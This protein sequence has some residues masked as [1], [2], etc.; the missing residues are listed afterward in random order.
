V[1]EGSFDH[2]DWPAAQAAHEAAIAAGGDGEAYQGLAVALF[3]QNEVDGAI[4]AMEHAY[5]LFRREAALGRAAWAALWIAGQYSRHKGNRSV[6]SGWVARCERLLVRA[7]PSAETGRV[8]LIRALA[9]NDPAQI[10]GAAE[11]AMEIA[12]RFGDSDYEALALAYSGLAMLSLGRLNEGRARLDEAMAATT[13]GE[14]RAPEAVGQI[15][16]AMLA[17]C[18][19]TVDFQRAEQWRQVA[20]PFLDAYDQVGVTGTCRATYAGVLAATGDWPEAELEL[21]HALR[22]FDAFA[23]G[24]RA[25]AVVRMA[26]LRIRQGRLDEATRLME[27]NEGHPDAQL[28][29]AELELAR[30]R[31]KVAAA[32]LERRLHQLGVANL[33]AAP[34]LLRLVEAQITAG[35]PTAARSSAAA[36]ARL[37]A[38]ADGDCLRGLAGLAQGLATAAEGG[39]PLA[40]LDVALEHLERARMRWEAARAR[41]AIAEAAATRNPELATREAR[42]AMEAFRALGAGPGADRARGLLRRL[43]VRTAGGPTVKAG[44]SQR[45]EEVARLVGLGLSNEQIAVRLFLSPRTVEHH[46]T[47][48]LRKLPASGRAEIAVY[49]ARHLG[50][51]SS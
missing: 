48:I 3:W 49:A 1:S 38:V 9:T 47:S 18:E 37:A 13:A 17:G 7:E 21:L 40:E 5:A 42:L 10:V 8:I 45:E 12:R 11:Q 44:L 23:Q 27:G 24:M 16:C 35:D 22:T 51:E 15:Y 25:D 46:V 41:L 31:P 32:L 19:Q 43:G 29:L 28:P 26:D 14:V 4:R 50:T 20:G 2:P 39:D 36:L 33:Q 34:L 6:A 30:G